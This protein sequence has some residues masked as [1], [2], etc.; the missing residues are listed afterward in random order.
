MAPPSPKEVF[1]RKNIFSTGNCIILKM[2]MQFSLFVLCMC[3]IE[4]YSS[5]ENMLRCK[6][7]KVPY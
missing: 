6:E 3:V 2:R 7:N 1:Y 4:R 5:F